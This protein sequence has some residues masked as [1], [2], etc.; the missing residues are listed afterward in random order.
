MNPK[1]QDLYQKI[2]LDHSRNPRNYGPID[3]KTTEAKGNNPLCGDR[4][5]VYLEI[6]RN[7]IVNVG[8]D[9]RGCAIS[10]AS[11]SI[12]TE[13]LLGK[14]TEESRSTIQEFNELL[15]E[16]E[17]PGLI[18][19]EQVMALS[20][21]KTFP[22]RIKCATLPWNTFESALNGESGEVTTE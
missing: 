21:V 22:T 10:V 7:R 4:V 20:A 9:A 1:L 14:T 8:F 2:I 17:P 16:K 13:K 12:M 19:D 6:D 18:K 5:S 3:S 15:A 11:A